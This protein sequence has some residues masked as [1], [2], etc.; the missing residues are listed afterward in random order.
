MVLI[1]LFE[2]IVFIGPR[3]T[4]SQFLVHSHH[5]KTFMKKYKQEVLSK[6][7]GWL[8]NFVRWYTGSYY[9]EKGLFKECWLKPVLI[10]I[11]TELLWIPIMFILIALVWFGVI[12]DSLMRFVGR[13]MIM[14]N[15]VRTVI[16]TLIYNR[17]DL[18]PRWA[19]SKRRR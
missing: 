1:I 4:V 10:I 9:L 14:E 5:S 13:I 19:R 18:M 8:S 12:S 6:E 11:N 2:N 15:G 7:R 16:N 3:I 17:V